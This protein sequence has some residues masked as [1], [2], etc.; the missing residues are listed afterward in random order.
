MAYLRG[1]PLPGRLGY[2]SGSTMAHCSSARWVEYDL[3]VSFHVDGQSY[4][5]GFLLGSL[6]LTCYWYYTNSRYYDTVSI[7]KRLCLCYDDGGCVPL[8]GQDFD[9]FYPQPSDPAAC[10]GYPCLKPSLKQDCAARFRGARVVVPSSV[11]TPA[12]RTLPAGGISYG[13]PSSRRE[14][15]HSHEWRHQHDFRLVDGGYIS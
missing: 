3:C 12:Q 15:K 13:L 14:R 9:R 5:T 10:I 11:L 6:A 4:R 1:R 2:S 8:A 7:D